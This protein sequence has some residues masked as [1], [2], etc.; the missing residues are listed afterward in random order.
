MKG[1]K[2]SRDYNKLKRLVEMGQDVVCFTT[3]DFDKYNSKPH[4]PMWTTDVCYC[5][6]FPNANPDYVRYAFL[7][8]GITFGDYWPRM[9]EGKQSFEDLCKEMKIEYIEPNEEV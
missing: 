5:R 2:T 3:W 4:E 9:D 8:R 1:Y 6:Y 7:A